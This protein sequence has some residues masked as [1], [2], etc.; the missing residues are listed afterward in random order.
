MNIYLVTD[1]GPSG[2]GTAG[3]YLALNFAENSEVDLTLRTQ[4]WGWGRNG[5]NF[6]AKGFSDTRFREEL[7]AE[8]F[9]NS[10]YLDSEQNGSKSN[11][12][13]EPGTNQAVESGQCMVR[14]FEGEEN[15]WISIGDISMA[16]K[17]PEDEEIYTVISTDFNLDRVPRDWEYYM[18]QVDEV[19]VP[20]KWVKRSIENTFGDN[21][22][23]LVEKVKVF[24]YGIPMNYEPTEYDCEACP[25]K[26]Q[27]IHVN[28]DEP[29]LRDEKFNFLVVSRF[30]HI[31]GIYRTVKAFLQE[32]NLDEDVRLFLKTTTNQQFNF[33]PRKSVQNVIQEV[34]KDNPPEIGIK[35]DPFTDQQIHDLMGQADAFIQAS[36]AECFGIAQ[37]QAAYCGTPVIAMNWSAQKELLPDESPGFLKINDF[38]V[39]KTERESD[40]FIYQGNNKFPPDGKWATPSIDALRKQMRKLFEEGSD[41]C[42]GRGEIARK[43]VEENFE[44]EEKAEERIEHLKEALK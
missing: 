42:G 35:V 5:E 3:R 2:F 28:P 11:F 19:W 41:K 7:L 31:K 13:E 34:G 21:R 27:N 10:D 38:R 25:N 32:F 29:C 37:L 12:I 17:A 20:S 1:T 22:Q 4:D 18:E 16:E 40:A 26:H 8:N 44:W 43:Y 33:D 15:V 36:R 6:E 9:V 30:Y 24:E 39:E 23:E 14:Q